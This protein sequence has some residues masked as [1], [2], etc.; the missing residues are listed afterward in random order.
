MKS[1]LRND[2]MKPNLRNAHHA[3][4]YMDLFATYSWSPSCCLLGDIES[5]APSDDAAFC[6]SGCMLMWSFCRP[7][8]ISA[9]RALQQALPHFEQKEESSASPSVDDGLASGRTRT[10]SNANKASKACGKENGTQNRSRPR[11]MG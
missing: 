8:K 9:Q 2:H 11:H 1:N 4:N 7:G 5:P 3:K 10:G 6:F